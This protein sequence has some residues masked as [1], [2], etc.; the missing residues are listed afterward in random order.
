[1]SITCAGCGHE[2]LD[3]VEFC[4][5]CGAELVATAIPTS[6]PPPVGSSSPP[7]TQVPSSPP[8]EQPM[9][10]EQIPAVTVSA[11]SPPAAAT[12]RLIAKQP[13]AS[14]SEFSLDGSNMLIGRYDADTTGPVDIDL[15]GFP[16][17]ETVSRNHAEIY[18]ESGQWKVNDL[19]SANGIFIRR[20]G[21]SRFGAR[22]TSPE[23][24]NP[25]DEVAFGK[26]RFVFQSP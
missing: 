2:N 15:E 13:S 9:E 5:V 21:D 6:S 12:A 14:V 26:V 3:G 7:I 25:G 8:V 18:M 22:L 11:V 16:D 19:G 10:N 24:L 1:M 4:E 20:V 23:V 17:E